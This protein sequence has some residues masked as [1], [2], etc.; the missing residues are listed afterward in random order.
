MPVDLVVDIDL[1][2]TGREADGLDKFRV[3]P[4]ACDTDGGVAR[5]FSDQLHAV[6]LGQKCRR[7]IQRARVDVPSVVFFRRVLEGLKLISASAWGQSLVLCTNVVD[8]GDAA[9]LLVDLDAKQRIEEN[10]FAILLAHARWRERNG[11][12]VAGC[13]DNL[14]SLMA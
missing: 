13:A 2:G 1:V 12:C 11:F 14:Q 8:A 7:H 9:S 10:K 5:V 3:L 6:R 4:T